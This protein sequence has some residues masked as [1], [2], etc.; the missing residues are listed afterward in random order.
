MKEARCPME[1]REGDEGR[2]QG[3]DAAGRAALWSV[4]VFEMTVHMPDIPPHSFVP[5]R[6]RNSPRPARDL[7]YATYRER[8]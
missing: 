3:P 7:E 8:T 2:K 6:A 4:A 5:K 1:D